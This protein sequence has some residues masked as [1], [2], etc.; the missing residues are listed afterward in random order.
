MARSRKVRKALELRK[1]IR[2]AEK[3]L[4]TLQDK[5]CNAV[6]SLSEKELHEYNALAFQQEEENND[7]D[8]IRTRP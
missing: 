5:K 1:Q 8:R 6:N 4:S 7:P 2:T 3:H